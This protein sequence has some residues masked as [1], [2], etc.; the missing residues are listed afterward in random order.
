MIV[1]S[2]ELRHDDLPLLAARA[3]HEDDAVTLRDG[4]GHDPGRADRLVVGMGVDGH[5]RGHGLML[6]SPP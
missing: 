2:V 3:G 4:L 6:P 5:E 1:G